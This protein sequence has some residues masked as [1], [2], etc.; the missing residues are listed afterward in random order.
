MKSRGG[1]ADD[2]AAREN[3]DGIN[4]NNYFSNNNIDN[5]Y[6]SNDYHNYC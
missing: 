3:K 5:N 4:N 2:T 1:T 6:N